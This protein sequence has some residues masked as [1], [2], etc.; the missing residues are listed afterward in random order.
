MRTTLPILFFGVLS[1]GLATGLLIGKFQETAERRE[2]AP[3]LRPEPSAVGVSPGGDADERSEV[4]IAEL[5]LELA[6]LRA[7]V[8][9][10]ERPSS[11]E[12][13]LTRGDARPEPSAV[14]G[15]IPSPD[16]RAKILAVMEQLETE[17]QHE[18][19]LARA[20][21][22]QAEYLRR[23]TK[24][25]AQ[26]SLPVGSEQRIASILAGEEERVSA[27]R[28]QF[29]GI[30]KSQDSRQA[31]QQA[32]QAT[33]TWRDEELSLAFGPQVVEQLQQLERRDGDRKD[34]RRGK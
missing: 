24:L 8:A 16:E 20:E 9:E 11:R 19:E 1:T 14:P 7:R 29:Q 17:R 15:P 10:L 4:A 6:A 21:K 5:S 23:A 2:D 33:R 18:K 34:R 3:A 22:Q 25:T 27:V 30:G 31:Y 28:A 26:L 13:V 12:A 32:L